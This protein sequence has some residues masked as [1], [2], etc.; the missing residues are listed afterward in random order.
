MGSLSSFSARCLSKSFRRSVRAKS[1]SSPRLNRRTI[2]EFESLSSSIVSPRLG[3]IADQ[4]LSLSLCDSRVTKNSSSK[5][6]SL[7][8]I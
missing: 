1:Q 7:L 6:V 4:S 3:R 5:S 2:I 8:A